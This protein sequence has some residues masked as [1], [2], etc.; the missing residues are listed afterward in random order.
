MTFWRRTDG[1]NETNQRFFSKLQ[2]NRKLTWNKNYTGKSKLAKSTIRRRLS[3]M[4]IPGDGVNSE[5]VN[6]GAKRQSH[7][8]G[9]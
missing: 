9:E 4:L 1:H 6:Y 8:P 7:I 2:R 5:Y 3:S